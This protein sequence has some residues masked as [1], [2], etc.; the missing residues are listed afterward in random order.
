[1]LELPVLLNPVPPLPPLAELLLSAT[2]LLP[3]CPVVAALACCMDTPETEG[4]RTT[5]TIPRRIIIK[6]FDLYI[7]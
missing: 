7:N 4:A 2:P 5:N 3:F 1:L 6:D